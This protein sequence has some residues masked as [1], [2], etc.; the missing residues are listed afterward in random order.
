[1][2]GEKITVVDLPADRFQKSPT[3]YGSNSEQLAGSQTVQIGVG[4]S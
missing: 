2:T 1:M 3:W 4:K